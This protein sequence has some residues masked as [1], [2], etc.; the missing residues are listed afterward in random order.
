VE[1]LI[2]HF[3]RLFSANYGMDPLRFEI[4]AQELL[5]RYDWPGNVRE[6]RN[7][8][9]SLVLM[10]T[11]RTIGL[12]DFPE[13]FLEALLATPGSGASGQPSSAARPGEEQEIAT[14]DQTERRMI[15]QAVAAAGGNVSL[16]ADKLGV[17]RSTLYRKLQQYRSMQ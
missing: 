2:D 17:S 8:V 14:L 11:G 6:L 16:A 7:L 12:D 10:S 5:H 4:Q 3:N 1:F 9:E 13:D 15:E